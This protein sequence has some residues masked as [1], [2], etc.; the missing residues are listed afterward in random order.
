MKYQFLG[1]LVGGISVLVF[2]ING[3]Q[4]RRISAGS[5]TAE[6]SPEEQMAKDYYRI[7]ED[8][9]HTLPIIIEET[10]TPPQPVE[11][12]V[13][14]IVAGDESI[15]VYELKQVP[16]TVIIDAMQN[17]PEEDSAPVDLSLFEFATRK[18]GKGN[19]PWTLKFAGKN[20]VL[21]SYGGQGKREATV[22]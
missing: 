18:V 13:P 12:L 1:F 16:L 20:A 21:V 10:T 19:H 7:P 22:T 3:L 4:L 6:S 8:D 14:S 5:F 17:W 9:R 15:A 11:S 2:A